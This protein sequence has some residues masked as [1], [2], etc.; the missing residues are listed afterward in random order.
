MIVGVAQI[1]TAI[2]RHGLLGA[3]RLVPKNLRLVKRQWT[4]R[5]IRARRQGREFDRRFGTRTTPVVMSLASLG[6]TEEQSRHGTW[7][8]PV[9]IDEMD[10]MLRSIDLSRGDFTF[11]DYGC[12]MG[13]PLLIASNYAF[14]RII[15][16][17]LLSP[18]ADI[19]RENIRVYRRPE[20]RCTAIEV[21]CRDARDYAPPGGNMVYFFANP[22]DVDVLGPVLQRIEAAHR[23][24]EEVLALYYC[25]VHRALFENASRWKRLPNSEEGLPWLT[26][27]LGP[28]DAAGPASLQQSA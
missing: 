19:A 3:V 28:N 1:S 11:V 2:R 14:A 27:R 17:E 6:A 15:G 21:L 12:G 25:P 16:V 5:W 4:R 8:Q 23:P 10:A 26:Y 9:V 13:L 22:F 24:G 20:Q 7:Y 18:L